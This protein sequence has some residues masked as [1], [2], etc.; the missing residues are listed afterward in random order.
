MPWYWL[1]SREGTSGKDLNVL[2]CQNMHSPEITFIM[3]ASTTACM[4]CLQPCRACKT[5]W[6]WKLKLESSSGRSPV[7]S[8]Y[9]A[10]CFV[11][12]RVD[13]LKFILNHSTHAL[14]AAL[15]ESRQGLQ[16]ALVLELQPGEQ[17]WQESSVVLLRGKLLCSGQIRHA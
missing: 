1:C 13:I 8:C 3:S 16:D 5:P 6:Y 11:L 15:G 9:G 17:F 7:L 14:S 12:P 4:F 2:L 10:S